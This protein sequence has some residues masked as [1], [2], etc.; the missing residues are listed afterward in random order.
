MFL[1]LQTLPQNLP[2]NVPRMRP[3]K[4][5]PKCPVKW[6]RFATSLA[7]YRSQKGLSLKKLRKK[8]E[9]GFPGPLSSTPGPRGPGNP[10]SDFFRSFLGRGL[11]DSCRR[12]TMSQVEVHLSCFHLFCSST[13]RILLPEIYIF[14]KNEK[15]AQRGSFLDGYPADIRGSLARISRPKTSVRALKM[16]EKQALVRGHP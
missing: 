13:L 2:R 6:S 15:S 10:F 12:P 3:R 4:C 5:P 7:F 8:S 14:I 11:F 16:L 9:K 1:A